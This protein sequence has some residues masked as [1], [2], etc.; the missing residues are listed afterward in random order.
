MVA[1][2]PV[3]R[4]WPRPA[5]IASLTVFALAVVAAIWVFYTR[6]VPLPAPKESLRAT[7]SV[8]HDDFVGAERCASCHRTEY[9]A[10]S[11][12]THGR[13]GGPPSPTTVIAPFSAPI[14]F[15]NAVVTPRMRSGT[16]EFTVEQPG[17]PLRSFRVSGV[18]GGGHMFGGGTQAFVTP[19]ED[20]TVRLLP[21]EWSRQ[22]GAWFCNTS[23]RSG[24]GWARIT[25][26]TRLEECGDWPPVRVLGDNARFANC[27]SCHASQ[28]TLVLDSVARRYTTRM[29]SLAINC[30]SCHGPG[31]RHIEI[32]ERI[33]TAGGQPN[34]TADIGMASLA[35]F[36]KDASL[37]VC[38]QCHS[39]KDQLRDGFLSG[40]TLARY[41]STRFPLLGDRPLF[42][43]GRVRTFAYQEGHQYSDCYLNGGMTCTS[44]HD[45]HDQK[46]RTVAGES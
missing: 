40:D 4:R 34:R 2:R 46:Y 9:A 39:V 14:V 43:D 18:V 37:R 8:S 12:S 11:R 35:T 24:R 33:A 26:E 19:N 1:R 20:G 23:S 44:C 31:R 7:A 28:A 6:D 5:I 38:Y 10:W 42:P 45:P 13:A 27:Q 36:E 41:Y 16:Y 30:E 15:R 17:E 22:A 25:R 29:T 21:F 3:T 32:I